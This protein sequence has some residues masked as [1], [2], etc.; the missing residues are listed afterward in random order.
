MNHLQLFEDFRI[1]KDTPKWFYLV[2]RVDKAWDSLLKM[3]FDGLTGISDNP[4]IINYWFDVRDTLLIMKGDEFL[5]LNPNIHKVDYNNPN[6]L[7]SNNFKLLNRLLHNAENTEH[8]YDVIQKI[9]SHS[10]RV[11]TNN[12]KYHLISK[13]LNLNVYKVEEIISDEIN[14]K[15]TIIN[16][17]WDFVNIIWKNLPTMVQKYNK[18]YPWGKPYDINDFDKNAIYFII[19]QGILK[20][21]ESW[22]NEGEWIIKKDKATN[23]RL[24]KVPSNSKLYFKINITDPKEIERMK[25]AN[26]WGHHSGIEDKNLKLV[27]DMIESYHLDKLYDV[28]FIQGHMKTFDI[29]KDEPIPNTIPYAQLMKTIKGFPKKKR[30][31]KLN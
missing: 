26:K 4:E 21:S 1:L 2:L 12:D 19:Q 30:K 18:N 27:T 5:K 7:I 13:F 28:E 10:E 29:W 11:K 15:N 20:L 17:V 14:D 6:Q 31:K 8:Y 9:L 25:A 23:K 3:E 24:L 22:T 16:N